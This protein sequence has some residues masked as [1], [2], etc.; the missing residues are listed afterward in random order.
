MG[1]EKGMR[2]LLVPLI[3]LAVAGSAQAQTVVLVRHA[4]KAEGNDPELT[5]A[6]Q[7]RAQALARELNGVRLSRI[8]AT[9]PRRTQLTAAPAASA[10]GLAVEPVSLEGGA[11]AHIARVA[12]EARKA[13]PG[14]T[15]LIVGHSNTVPEIARALGDPAPVALTDCDYDSLT[16]IDL[17]PSPPTVAHKRYGAPTKAC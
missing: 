9:P 13:K 4:E 1:Q 5:A 8:L 3:A 16:V 2:R 10:A 6:G 17:S 12:A 14:E 7:A 11:A 15:V